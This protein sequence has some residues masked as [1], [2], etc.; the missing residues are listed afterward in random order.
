M[1]KK[2]IED[3][4]IYAVTAHYCLQRHNILPSKFSSLSENEKAF[5]IASTEIYLNNKGDD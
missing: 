4:N 1:C 5:I 2:L 3:G